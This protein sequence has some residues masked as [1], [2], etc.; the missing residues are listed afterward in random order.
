MMS[1]RNEAPY[2]TNVSVAAPE[3]G[4]YIS[5]F[6][7]SSFLV[8][9]YHGRQL[10]IEIYINTFLGVENKNFKTEFEWF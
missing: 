4:L 10:G 5:Y 1:R 9:H 2:P 6:L 7:S 3:D 8:K